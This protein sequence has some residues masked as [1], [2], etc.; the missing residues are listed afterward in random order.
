[1]STAPRKTTSDRF[2]DALGNRQAGV[3]DAVRSG[4]ERYHRFNRSLIES[5]RQGSRD[6]LEVGRR[7]VANP[8]DFV[9]VYEAASDA[10]GNGQAR[11]LALTREWIEDA[12]E[13]QRETR[14]VVRQGFGDV[15]EAVERV[16]ANAPPLLRR[17]VF[18]RANN[19]ERQATAP[20]K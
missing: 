7:W 17:A 10:L 15:R 6:W 16:Q 8:L 18:A 19:S 9:G 5:A 13:S 3:Y 1:M 2:F 20:E 4:N 12:V 14:E 11:A